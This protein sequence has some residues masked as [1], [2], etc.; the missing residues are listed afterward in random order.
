M[1]ATYVPAIYYPC[2]VCG[3]PGRKERRIF[4][5]GSKMDLK[6]VMGQP[7]L[8]QHGL[9]FERGEREEHRRRRGILHAL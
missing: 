4:F 8:I 7:R 1:G 9:A 2:S 3:R 5:Q 6:T